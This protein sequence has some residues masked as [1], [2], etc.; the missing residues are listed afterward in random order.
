MAA[1]LPS[2]LGEAAHQGTQARLFDSVSPQRAAPKRTPKLTSCANSP[3]T[4][5]EKRGSLVRVV[6]DVTC[7]AVTETREGTGPTPIHS[8]LE[9]FASILPPSD[10]VTYA[11]RQPKVRTTAVSFRCPRAKCH[12]CFESDNETVGQG[13]VHLTMRKTGYRGPHQ[14]LNGNGPRL[15]IQLG[16]KKI[17]LE[18]GDGAYLDQVEGETVIINSVGDGDAEF[19]LFDLAEE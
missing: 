1:L 12:S 4:D 18:E 17:E 11:F 14:D 13:Y 15:S 5:E 16:E 10:T 8:H 19:V 9:M 7:P 3:Y 6:A 2:D